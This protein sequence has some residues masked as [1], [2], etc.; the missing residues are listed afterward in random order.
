VHVT[1]FVTLSVTHVRPGAQSVAVVQV[2]PAGTL[3]AASHTQSVP[4]N[5]HVG[6]VPLRSH[7]HAGDGTHALPDV[8]TGQPFIHIPV[9]DTTPHP[10]QLPGSVCKLMQV[11]PPQ[12]ELPEGHWHELD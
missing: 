8:A 3:P 11:V 1:V 10:P 12:K 5:S 4:L 2:P 7:P 6:V 9:G